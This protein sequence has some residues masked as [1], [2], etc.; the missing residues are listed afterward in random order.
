M[1]TTSRN[2]AFRF[3]H[4]DTHIWTQILRYRFKFRFRYIY[5]YRYRYGYKVGEVNKQMEN[6]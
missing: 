6:R 1:G 5:R 3:G 4:T 2:K